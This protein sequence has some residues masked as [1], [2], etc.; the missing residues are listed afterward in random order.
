MMLL[1][2]PFVFMIL[3]VGVLKDSSESRKIPH[4][5]NLLLC[6]SDL[7]GRISHTIRP[8]ATFFVAKGTSLLGM[9]VN[10]FFLFIIVPT[11]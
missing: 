4:T 9:N 11:P 3:A 5:V 8:Y 7:F 1:T 2:I 6:V 10:V